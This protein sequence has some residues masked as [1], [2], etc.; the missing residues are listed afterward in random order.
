MLLLKL[1]ILPQM[2]SGYYS[3]KIKTIVVIAHSLIKAG[4]PPSQPFS[5]Y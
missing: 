4:V 1:V 2:F 3:F 5:G